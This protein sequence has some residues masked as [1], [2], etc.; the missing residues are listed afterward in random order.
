MSFTKGCYTGQELVAR[1][2][3]RGNKVPRRLRGVVVAWSLLADI[4][5][6]PA[7]GA[8]LASGEK[9]VGE[10]T[11]VASSPGLEALVAMA[12][13]RREVSPPAELTL[14]WE[15]GS[16][17]AQVRELPLIPGEP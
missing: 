6:W 12:Y 14:R 8:Q 9:V 16:V 3:S 7:G 17:P 1:L 5:E 11:S 13:V 15:A 2:D 10:L 4:G